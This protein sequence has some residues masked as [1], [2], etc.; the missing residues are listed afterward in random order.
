ML[1]ADAVT[2]ADGIRVSYATMVVVYLAL[3]AMTVVIL[4]RLARVPRQRAGAPGNRD[5][6]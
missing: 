5:A 6:G 4:R 1:T 2:D 3:I